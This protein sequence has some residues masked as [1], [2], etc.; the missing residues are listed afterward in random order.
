MDIPDLR[1]RLKARDALLTKLKT[2]LQQSQNYMK[3]QAHK[4]RKDV[5]L[6]VGDLVLVKLQPYRQHSVV[7]QKNQKLSLRYFGPFKIFE[8]IASVAKMH[9]VF[10]I[11]LL[12]EFKGDPTQ[13]YFPLPLT[14]NEFGPVM[15]P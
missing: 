8:K 11:S 14:T 9:V 7:L 2:K 13:Q 15:C 12:N 6:N 1:E 4:K 5:Q 3:L 10:L